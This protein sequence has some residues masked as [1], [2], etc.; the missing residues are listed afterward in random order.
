VGITLILLIYLLKRLILTNHRDAKAA[1]ETHEDFVHEMEEGVKNLKIDPNSS[2]ES[3]TNM[4]NDDSLYDA[5]EVSTT[6]AGAAPP[7]VPTPV[8]EQEEKE[9]DLEFGDFVSGD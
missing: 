8:P 2:S 5:D 7:C 6:K 1:L 3:H 9:D 4:K